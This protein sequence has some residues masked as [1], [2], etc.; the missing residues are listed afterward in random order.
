VR[1]IPAQLKKV[2]RATILSLALV[3]GGTAF[4]AYA[5]TAAEEPKSAQTVPAKPAPAQSTPKLAAPKPKVPVSTA[6]KLAA[7]ILASTAAPAAAK[8][9]APKPVSTKPAAP[10]TV[11]TATQT[12]GKTDSTTKPTAPAQTAA[13][14]T[15]LAAKPAA[16]T[17][18]AAA[19]TTTPAAVSTK[20]AAAPAAGSTTA[21]AP[22]KTA[23]K[24]AKP[25]PKTI[26]DMAVEGQVSWT[27]AAL[28]QWITVSKDNRKLPFAVVD[29][30]SAQ[31]L[32]FDEKGKLKAMAP[33]LIGAAVGDTSA[34]GVG[35]RELKDIPMED[36]TTPAGRF[37]AG[38]GPASG[39]SKVLWIDYATAISIHPVL[40]TAAAKKEKRTQRLASKES[41]DNRI[42]HGC[43]NVSSTFY[44]NTIRSTFGKKGGVFY[45]IPDSISLLDAFPA[46]EPP[47]PEAIA[48][49]EEPVKPAEPKQ[50]KA[51]T[52]SVQKSAPPKTTVQKTTAQKTTTTALE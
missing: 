24:K 22:V 40:T 17:T 14:A 1:A 9:A 5:Q 6:D 43:I 42:T 4:G 20:T 23:A 21:K 32:V 29:K 33:I 34:E 18:Q 10:A 52:A 16:T 12:A 36:R 13:K 28:T 41:D 39:H 30:N 2:L 11:T 35:D 49:L 26:E 27:S 45:V 25:K 51:K 7:D 31:I 38:Y 8:A 48:A 46:Y 15:A 50:A 44:A 47:T 19:K 3:G 37:V